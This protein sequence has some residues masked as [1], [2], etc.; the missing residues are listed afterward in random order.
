MQREIESASE[1]EKERER[2]SGGDRKVCEGTQGM[3]S[4]TEVGVRT[5]SEKRHT[6]SSVGS[7]FSSLSLEKSLSHNP[8][9]SLNHR[10]K[11]TNECWEAD[12]KNLPKEHSK[13]SSLDM[14][15]MLSTGSCCASITS[16]LSSP[17][18]CNQ[19]T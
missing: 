13:L 16:N 19:T 18:T 10:N 15:T 12:F 6:V 9:G 2:E 8:V 4:K 7:V 17:A 3:D 11:Q 5:E 1:R 14:V